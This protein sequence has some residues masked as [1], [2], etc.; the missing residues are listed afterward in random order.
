MVRNGTRAMTLATLDSLVRTT[1]VS[2]EVLLAD[3]ASTDGPAAESR[4]RRGG[5]P[6]RG[7]GAGRPSVAAQ[8]R[9][10]LAGGC[11]RP[12][13]LRRRAAGRADPGRADGFR[14]R[15]A[16]SG[17]GPAA[18]A[19]PGRAPARW[20]RSPPP[21]SGSPGGAWRRRRAVSP[22]PCCAFPPW[23]RLP[24]AL[25]DGGSRRNGAPGRHGGGGSDHA[26]RAGAASVNRSAPNPAGF[27]SV[28][29][30]AMRRRSG[31]GWPCAL[32]AGH[33]GGG[34]PHAGREAAAGRGGAAGSRGAI[35][36]A[37]RAFRIT[38]TS[39]TSCSRAPCTGER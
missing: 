35:R 28:E 15:A 17:L 29:R 18:S 25:P 2:R 16:G 23:A 8:Q 38:A 31:Q 12:S 13:V 34:S 7:T 39:M 3:N 27:R 5:R 19:R 9:S 37:R 14:P 6:R 26:G 30:A 4:L 33:V 32:G 10:R 21:G 36:K 24:R 1:R 22:W 20:R 11:R